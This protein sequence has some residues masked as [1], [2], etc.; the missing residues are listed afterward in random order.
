MNDGLTDVRIREL[1]NIGTTSLLGLKKVAHFEK[2]NRGFMHPINSAFSTQSPNRQQINKAHVESGTDP[3]QEPQL[4]SVI[5]V[6]SFAVMDNLLY[7]GMNIGEGKGVFRDG[8]FSGLMMR[9]FLGH[10]SP[11]KRCSIPLKRWMFL[12][13]TVCQY[14]W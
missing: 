3:S 8:D 1:T 12:I 14:V 7:I 11:L 9:A 4:P 2:G 13:N 5:R 10:V 6:D